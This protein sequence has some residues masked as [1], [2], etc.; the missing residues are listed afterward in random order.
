MRRYQDLHHRLL[1][2]PNKFAKTVLLLSTVYLLFRV[3]GEFA[4]EVSSFTDSLFEGYSFWLYTAAFCAIAVMILSYRHCAATESRRF[5]DRLIVL[6]NEPTENLLRRAGF[7]R[8]V[9][10]IRRPMVCIIVGAAFLC[11]FVPWAYRDAGGTILGYEW[12]MRHDSDNRWIGE[13]AKTLDLKIFRQVRL[14]ILIALSFLAVC[15]LCEFRPFRGRSRLDEVLRSIRN[16]AAVIVLFLSFNYLVFMQILEDERLDPLHIW[17]E[18][19]GAMLFYSPA[20]GYW[21]F[22][23][24]CVVLSTL[25]L[26]GIEGVP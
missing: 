20:F 1:R 6:P 21:I 19:Q 24:L 22:T 11:L 9:L 12:M 18:S 3:T 25:S 7:Q 26:S 4:D 23:V 16:L 2:S 5:S 10:L 15:L 17:Q 14:E 13:A 8:S